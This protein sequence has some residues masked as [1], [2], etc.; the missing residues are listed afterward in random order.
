[1]TN[2]QRIKCN[3]IIH[4][5][6]ISAGGVGAGLAQLPCSDSIAIIPIQMTMSRELS[7]VRRQKTPMPY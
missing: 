2:E 5:V 7:E 4:A 6:A 1:M 3:A